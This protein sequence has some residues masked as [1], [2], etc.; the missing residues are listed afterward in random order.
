MAIHAGQKYRRQYDHLKFILRERAPYLLDEP[1]KGLEDF[2]A[3]KAGRS[4][5]LVGQD[6]HYLSYGH[7]CHGM[8][9][10]LRNDLEAGLEA[11]RLAAWYCYWYAQLEVQFVRVQRVSFYLDLPLE[12]LHMLVAGY[13]KPVST[14]LTILD[15][16]QPQRLEYLGGYGGHTPY[17]ARLLQ[18][19]SGYDALHGRHDGVLLPWYQTLLDHALEPDTER[20]LPAVTAAC[21]W[22]IRQTRNTTD[23]TTYCFDSP[24]YMLYPVE[25]LAWLRLRQ[26]HGLEDGDAFCAAHPLM[27][28]P[29]GRLYDYAP[30]PEG[31]PLARAALHKMRERYPG[32]PLA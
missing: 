30:F 19:F 21:D 5:F 4:H 25:I 27:Q 10:L 26:R 29:S 12:L 28:L 9:S 11:N 15:T 18:W 22:H 23:H 3:G 2:V 31:P 20:L 13:D 24:P 1:M 32:L 16:D 7:L 6:F 17:S 14:L 8:Y